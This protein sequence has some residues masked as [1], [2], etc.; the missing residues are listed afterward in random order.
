[1]IALRLIAVSAAAVLLGMEAQA[2]DIAL[3]PTGPAQDSAFIRFVNASTAPLQVIAREGQ[4]PLHLD[5]AK[6]VSLFFPV[7]ASSSIKGT[8]VSGDEKLPMDVSVEPGE[9][10]TVVLTTQADG[11]LKPVTVREQPDDFNGLKASLAFFSLDA[12][13]GDAGLRPAGRS[14]DL[15]K[16]VATGTLQRR[17][18]NP[19]NLSVQ[20]VCANATVGEPLDLGEL[21]PGERYSVL[22]VPSATGPRLLSATDTLSN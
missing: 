9:F 2:A 17:S 11:S 6:P 18:I 12:G 15:F 8:L 4:T 7:Q 1:M 22:L 21:K 13:C 3:Y 20:L 10:A 5:S 14:A 19:V 16:A